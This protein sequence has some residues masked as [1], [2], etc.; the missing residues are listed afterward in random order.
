M[1]ITTKAF[2]TTK[3]GEEVTLYT[4]ENKNGMKVSV[5]NFGAII[6]DIVVAD[7]N[8][9]LEDINLG[10]DN[11]S[12][13]EEKNGPGFGSFIGRHANRIGGASFTIEG[14]TFD[15]EKNDGAN[16]LH[17]G[18]PGYNKVVYQ[19]E[20]KEEETLDTVS[21]TRKSPDGEQGFPG[22]VNMTMTYQLTE[23]NE[24]VLIY[25]AISDKDTL[26]NF[27]NHAYFNLAGHDSGN[28]LAQ[29]VLI[30][31]NAFTIIVNTY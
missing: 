4:M 17:G 8:G 9:K 6:V 23:S 22:E 12:D 20:I 21:F 19:T 24:L 25:D 26:M 16:N 10:Y 29:K 5:I 3:Q 11:L 27:T 31:A 2:G 7:R 15:L 30:K 18:T 14:T 1:S 13:Y 28:V